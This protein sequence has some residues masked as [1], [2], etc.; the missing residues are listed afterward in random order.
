MDWYTRPRAPFT[1]LAGVDLECPSRSLPESGDDVVAPASLP[2]EPAS[3]AA[4]VMR[5]FFLSL[6]RAC[7]F[8]RNGK[9]LTY[10]GIRRFFLLV[11]GIVCIS[12]GSFPWLCRSR[13]HLQ[14]LTNA[15]LS[16]LLTVDRLKEI[17]Q[18]VLVKR[19]CFVIIPLFV[20][21]DSSLDQLQC[22][23]QAWRSFRY[24]RLK[25]YCHRS[26][27]NCLVK[28]NTLDDNSGIYHFS[29]F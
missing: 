18:S 4:G 2:V 11:R 21:G 13:F 9:R 19:E 23:F 16:S 25:K 29:I 5:C 27:E 15:I 14:V 22:G 26:T 10:W 20:L 7:L 17:N 8:S 12:P 6:E 24:V 1:P 28:I 3:E